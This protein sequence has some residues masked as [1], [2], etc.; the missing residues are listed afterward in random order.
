MKT[1]RS[2]CRG[3]FTLVELLAGIMIMAVLASLLFVGISGV[4]ESGNRVKCINNLRQLAMAV[5]QFARDNDVF[6]DRD[7]WL[8]TDAGRGARTGQLYKYLGD[9]KLY[10]CPSDTVLT[11]G[12]DSGNASRLTSYAYNGWFSGKNANISVDMSAAVV[13]IEPDM[14]DQG[15]GTTSFEGA[16]APALTTR[17]KGGGLIG[18]GDGHYEYYSRIKY[19]ANKAKIFQVTQ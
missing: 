3:G 8:A 11:A 2:P 1:R 18:Y 13:F 19:E 5:T 6:P 16:G 15:P 7:R 17:H 9:A 10:A 12:L 14:P 4:R